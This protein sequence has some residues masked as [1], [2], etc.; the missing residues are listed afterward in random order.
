VIATSAKRADPTTDR[1][2]RRRSL[3]LIPALPFGIAAFLVLLAVCAPLITHDDPIKNDILNSLQ[4][5]AWISGGSWAH[6]LGTDV[7]GRDLLSRLLYGA[8]V[9]LGVAGLSMLIATAIGTSLGL[10]AGYKGGWVDSIIMRAVDMVLS[11]PILLLALAM[12][13]ALGPSFGIMVVVIGLLIWPTFARLIRGETLLLRN[14]EFVRYARV[15]GVPGWRIVL[16]HVLPNVMPT[17]LVI[18]TLEVG[19]IVLIEATLNF[20]GAG[21][22]LP[23]PSWGAMISEGAPLIVTGWWIA[24]F[25]GLAIVL[26]VATFNLLGDWLRDRYDP[27]IGEI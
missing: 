4:P 26:T 16:R 5:P 22:P 7:F 13:I 27:R 15:I 10:V 17:L 20:L 9:D 21:I 12:A 3:H 6:P 11:L 8:R 1:R 25:P 23:Q 24:L 2:S 14:Q 18:A 19:R